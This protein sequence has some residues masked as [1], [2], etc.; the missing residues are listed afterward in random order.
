M[1]KGGSSGS[2][3][4]PEPEPKSKSDPRKVSVYLPEPILG[5]IQTEAERRERS[6]SWILQKSWKMAR[7][8]LRKLPV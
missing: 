3:R 6:L 1:G 8:E 2:R 4:A 7:E 5:E